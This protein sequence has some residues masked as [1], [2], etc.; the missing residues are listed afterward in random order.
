MRV[1]LTL[2]VLVV[3]LTAIGG[4]LPIQASD[5]PQNGRITFGKKDPALGDT[6]IWAANPDGSDQQRLTNV[7]S[8]FSDWSP[9]GRRIAFDF[10]D[11]VGVHLA[12]MTPEGGNVRQLTFGAGIQEIPKWSPD[13]RWITFDAST[14]FPDDPAF[15]TSIWVMRADGSKARQVTHDGFDVEPVFSPDGSQI[16]FARITGVTAQ[17]SQLSGIWVVNVDGTGLHEVL[18]PL[19]GLE[20][21]D[22]SPDGRWLSFNIDPQVPDGLAPGA[23]MVVHPNG[24]GLRVLRKASSQFVFFKPV[25]SPDGRQLLTGCHDLQAQIDKLCVVD[26]RGRRLKVVISTPEPVNYPAWGSHS[27]TG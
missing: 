15:T 26:A 19:A 13:G 27:P 7:V 16:A 17:N 12:A 22:W 4:A 10:V 6:S 1:R 5:G 20:H 14:L 18:A 11:D 25:W 21:P 2:A 24:R 9:D 8:F 23:I 3:V